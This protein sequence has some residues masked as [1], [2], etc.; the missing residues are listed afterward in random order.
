MPAA[1]A[2]SILTAQTAVVDEAETDA[3]H[4]ACV[5]PAQ[6]VAPVGALYGW[7]LDGPAMVHV[8][9]MV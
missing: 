3:V 7:L 1:V 6:S 8:G 4:V 5:P 2:L 9:A